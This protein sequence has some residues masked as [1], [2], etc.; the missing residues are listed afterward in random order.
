MYIFTAADIVSGLERKLLCNRQ[1]SIMPP[2]PPSQ[3]YETTNPFPE[4]YY[5]SV[6]T[7]QDLSGQY[8]Y[9]L[10]TPSDPPENRSHGRPPPKTHP[11]HSGTRLASNTMMSYSYA[12]VP[13]PHSSQQ[14]YVN[15]G[16][17]APAVMPHNEYA[18]PVKTLK[19]KLANTNGP[20]DVRGAQLDVRAGGRE[21]AR[22]PQ[23]SY[24]CVSRPGVS[25]L[26]SKLFC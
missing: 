8:S 24:A 13:Q 7:D 22:E 2:V 1:N 11:A 4:T 14:I 26:Q 19:T 5:S 17:T 21:A 9:S 23:Y 16:G 10:V 25:L 3:H 20:S 15:V 6:T 12:D 18:E